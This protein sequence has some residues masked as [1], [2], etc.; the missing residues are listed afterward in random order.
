MMRARLSRAAESPTAAS[1]SSDGTSTDHPFAAPRDGERL[2]GEFLRTRDVRL[3]N[4]IVERYRG[5]VWQLAR[6]LSERGAPPEDLVQVG[7]VGLIG[8]IERFDPSR[9]TRFITFATA[10]VLGTMKG[11][12]WNQIGD[13]KVPRRAYLSALRLSRIRNCLERSLRRAPTAGEWA[14]AAGVAEE[15]LLAAPEMRR[16][17]RCLSLDAVLQD[18]GRPTTTVLEDLVGEVDQRLEAFVEREALGGALTRLEKRQR[19]VL[20]YRFFEG[21]SQ[22][23]VGKHLGLS[24]MHV[25][26]L[27]RE[28]L[29]TLRAHLGAASQ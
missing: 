3:R 8:A 24:Q 10:T 17:S 22:Q 2:I 25:S 26:R 18:E 13:M 16:M 20:Y 14:A 27:E 1:L 15:Q 4:E 12:L 21:A 5:T 19:A 29:K 28:A 6:R 23:Q 7:F 9:G 11:Y